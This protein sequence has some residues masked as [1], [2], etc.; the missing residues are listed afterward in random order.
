MDAQESDVR[1]ELDIAFAYGRRYGLEDLR[2]VIASVVPWFVS[3]VLEVR[4][5]EIPP[6]EATYDRLAQISQASGDVGLR[7]ATG[8]DLDDV[9]AAKLPRNLKAF[10]KR[11]RRPLRIHPWIGP[12]DTATYEV[13]IALK[14]DELWGPLGP[15]VK[16][17]CGEHELL[18]ALATADPVLGTIGIDPVTPTVHGLAT[19]QEKLP[20]SGYLGS[21]VARSLGEAFLKELLRGCPRVETTR[22][23]GI[24]YSWNWGSTEALGGREYTAFR[25][26]GPSVAERLAGARSG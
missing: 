7:L 19:G 5:L 24:F 17:T 4:L 10:L 2:R 9:L 16:A 18:V 23:G 21:H 13:Y 22:N 6:A 3:P 15:I 8:K 20:T 14:R 11:D 12:D 25:S 1:L 26:R